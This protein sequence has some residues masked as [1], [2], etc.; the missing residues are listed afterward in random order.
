[1]ASR[2]IL[3]TLKQ[4]HDDLRALFD[5]MDDTTDRALEDTRATPA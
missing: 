2:N 4:E 5:K 3:T 1:M